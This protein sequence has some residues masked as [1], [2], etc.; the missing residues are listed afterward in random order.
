M[1]LS[2]WLGE[3]IDRAAL[4]EH[5]STLSRLLGAICCAAFLWVNA[6]PL[7][8]VAW[9]AVDLA[10]EAFI[11]IVVTRR[12]Q[13][14]VAGGPALRAAYLSSAA[15]LTA[16]WS[17]QAAIYWFSGQHGLQIVAI[18][19]TAGQMIHAQAFAYRSR[20]VLA[21]TAGIP[22][23]MLLTLT[24]GFG[25][26][27]GA[28]LVSAIFAMVVTLSHVVASAFA[29]M[30]AAKDLS[31][32]YEEVQ[33]LA[34]L[35]A[36]TGLTNRRMFNETLRTLLVLSAHRRAKFALV[37][38]DLDGLKQVNDILGHD[39]GDAL[40]VEAAARL[41]ALI[42]GPDSLARVGGDEFAVLLADVGELSDVETLCRRIVEAFQPAF[43]FHGAGM[44][45]TTSVGAA[46]FPCDGED[47]QTIFKSA[48]LA[49]YA[50]KRGGRNTWRFYSHDLAA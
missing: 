28:A 15:L 9:L 13:K 49:L 1:S 37:L 26:L 46:I 21:V 8:G 24:L 34:Y 44:K 42:R 31:A 33:S 30:K 27:H 3:D 45:S 29:N 40:L 25:G 12:L 6:S 10:A 17:G 47:Q 4:D 16:N 41:K 32:A 7:T 23:A 39:A 18:M 11:W 14:G 20:L 43:E 5:R 19:V 48:D 38:I 35:D 50:A 36:L 2:A 22:A